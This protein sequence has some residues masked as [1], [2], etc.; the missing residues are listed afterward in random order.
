MEITAPCK[1]T[2]QIA[3]INSSQDQRPRLNLFHLIHNILEKLKISFHH[4]FSYFPFIPSPYL[5]LFDEKKKIKH[6]LT[7]KGYRVDATLLPLIE[8][9][10]FRKGKYLYQ[11][12][13]CVTGIS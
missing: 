7:V 9:R 3:S 13:I 8:V 6:T 11:T 12:G 10:E 1:L 5:F 4:H 2:Y